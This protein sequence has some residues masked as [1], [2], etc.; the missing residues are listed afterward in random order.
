[1]ENKKNIKKQRFDKLPKRIIETHTG[2]NRE[3]IDKL[4]DR[5]IDYNKICY[6]NDTKEIMIKNWIKFNQPSNINTIKCVNRELK[7]IKNKEYIDKAYEHFKKCN[8][9]VNELFKGIFDVNDDKK[10]SEDECTNIEV[11]NVFEKNIHI[12]TPM[13]KEKIAL[14]SLKYS[15]DIVILAIGEAVNSDVKNL[16]YIEKILKVWE[17]KGLRSKEEVK[18]YIKK[19]SKCG[20]NGE[21]LDSEYKRKYDFKD[22]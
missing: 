5:F 21:G 12:T 19:W 7:N 15:E 4:L 16:R 2:Y 22:L 3:T 18:E 1:M 10:I 14:W 8:L 17:E 13:E 6:C 20:N 11:L 9:N